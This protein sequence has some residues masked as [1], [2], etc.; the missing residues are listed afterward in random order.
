MIGQVNLMINVASLFPCSIIA[1]KLNI[2]VE[3]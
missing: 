2:P 1:I 3:M